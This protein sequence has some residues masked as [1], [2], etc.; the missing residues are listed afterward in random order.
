MIW[1]VNFWEKNNR[2]YIEVSWNLHGSFIITTDSVLFSNDLQ[3]MQTHPRYTPMPACLF[4]SDRLHKWWLYNIVWEAKRFRH[5]SREVKREKWSSGAESL[6]LL[7]CQTKNWDKIRDG[8]MTS[9]G[10]T[11][12]LRFLQGAICKKSCTSLEFDSNSWWVNR[13]WIRTQFWRIGIGIGTSY[14]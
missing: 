1:V 7:I 12:E 13:P 9:S 11:H 3:T 6:V 2:L 4:P 14:E 5:S 8:I 10:L